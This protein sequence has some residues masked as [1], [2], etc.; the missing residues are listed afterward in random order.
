M[1]AGA[2]REA[3]AAPSRGTTIATPAPAASAASCA[4][5]PRPSPPSTAST[6]SRWTARSRSTRATPAGSIGW[7]PAIGCAYATRSASAAAPGCAWSVSSPDS[8]VR[9]R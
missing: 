3:T 2:P 7:A 8:P 5:R 4:T 1:S 6:I 9:I